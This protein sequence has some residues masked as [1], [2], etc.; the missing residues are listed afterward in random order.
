MLRN[1]LVY[2]V[3][4]NELELDQD[5]RDKRRDLIEKAATELDNVSR[6]RRI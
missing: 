5:L 3:T 4:Q 2:G 6:N 1:P